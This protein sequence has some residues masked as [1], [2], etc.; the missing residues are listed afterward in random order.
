M[1][2]RLKIMIYHEDNPDDIIAFID[3][4][5]G[6]ITLKKGYQLKLGNNLTVNINEEQE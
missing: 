1:Q 4:E 6:Q 5:A 3:M 2:S